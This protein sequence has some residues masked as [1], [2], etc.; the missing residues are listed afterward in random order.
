M[1]HV[2]VWRGAHGDP[3]PPFG[4]LPGVRLGDTLAYE[5]QLPD[6]FEPWPGRT[7]LERVFV[8]LDLG[9]SMARPCWRR[10]R[11]PDGGEIAG[12]DAGLD[13]PAT[14]Y[15]DLIHVTQEQDRVVLRDLYIDVMVPTDGRH[16]RLLDLH[17]FADAVEDDRL[18]IPTAVDALR[19]WQQFLDRHL[20]GGRDPA[21]RWTDFP[22]QRVRALSGLPG[23][24]GPVVTVPG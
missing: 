20:H 11:A 16:Q 6:R 13:E 21:A 10:M 15:V 5:F 12:I 19:R 2:E 8:L 14:W 4:P 18:D 3:V 1:K 17:E 24:L 7:L 9:V 23:P 22:P